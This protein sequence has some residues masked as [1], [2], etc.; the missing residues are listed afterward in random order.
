MKQYRLFP[1]LL[2]LVIVS[3]SCHV[4]RNLKDGEYMLT[5]NVVKTDLKDPQFDDLYYYVR[6]TPNKKFIDLIPFKTWSYVAFQPKVTYTADGDSIVKDSKVRQKIRN[7]GEAPVLLDSSSI[8]YSVK[9]LKLAMLQRGYFNADVTPSL[10]FKK[11]K[12]HKVKVTYNVTAN[13]AYYINKIKYIIDIPEYKKIIL[14]DT[15]NRGLKVGSLY[16]QAELLAER[17]RITKHIRNNGYFHVSNDIVHFVIDTLHSYVLPQKKG[18]TVDIEIHVDFSKITDPEIREK[19]AY[20]YQFNDVYIY[21]NYQSGFQYTR[22]NSDRIRY[23]RGKKDSTSYYIIT[24][25]NKIK[26]NGK[27]K[28]RKDFK[29]KILSDNILTKKGV[30]YTDDAVS[31]S[32][33]KLNDLNNFNFIN[34]DVSEVISMR[35]TVNRTGVL[36][37]TYRLTR[38]KLHSLAAEIDLRSDKGNVSL[39]YSNKN[40]FRS[41]EFFNINVYGGADI[42]S[43]R[44]EEG[45]LK[46]ISE[47]IDAGGELSIDFKRLLLFRKTQKIEA[48]SYGTLIKA[49]VHF[50]QAPLYQ[51]WLL[52]AA[53]TYRWSPNYKISHTLSPLDISIINITNEDPSFY[54]VLSRYSLA[55]QK[56]YQDNVLF[57][58]KYTVH[59]TPTMRD[60]RNELRIQFK[61][62]SSGMFITGINALANKVSGQDKEWSFFGLKYA[63][64]ELA[65]LD[66]RF[67]HNFNKKNTI[68]MRFDLGVGV[69]MFKSPTLPFERSFFLGNANS[70]RAWEY[71][72]LGP[73][74]YYSE[75][76]KERSGDIKMEVNLEYRGPIYKFIKFGIFADAGNVWLT[77]KNEEMPNAEFNFTRFYKEI[78]LGVGAGIRLDFSFFLIRFDVGMPIYDPNELEGN[79]WVGQAKKMPTLK[80]AIGHAF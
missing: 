28:P 25:K 40:L 10:K 38:S 78:A 45:K 4:T 43:R 5:K 60:A 9:Q 58:F 32:Y 23:H 29:Y 70:M 42:Q 2:I 36:N 49:G 48:V 16:N 71:R 21:S 59:C 17:E 64:F 13:T 50:Q 19:F 80:F 14:L 65:E 39:T 47:N 61:F 15:V 69:P 37:T 35:D 12:Q 57:S 34:I 76:R 56:K 7:K 79:R 53:I 20:K 52:N 62:E 24:E 33:K 30:S 41:A 51:R 31:R 27:Y 11:E 18:K 67:K 77:K 8:D 66:L 73:G 44:N 74:S 63:N 54:E 26:K 6:P 55:F 1:F 72:S 75:N 46:L 3:S 68:A 22:E